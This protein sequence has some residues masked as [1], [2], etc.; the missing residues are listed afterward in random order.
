MSVAE[1]RTARTS[2]LTRRRLLT[3]GAT[4]ALATACGVPDSG[5]SN[6]GLKAA[7]Y[8]TPAYKDIFPSFQVL[9]DAIKQNSG[10]KVAYKMF[11]SEALLDAEQ[12]IPGILQGVADLGFQTSSYISTSYP[13]L[14]AYELPFLSDE[15][16]TQERMLAPD[17]PL[18]G[19]FN[20]EL[21]KKGLRML[22][23]ISTAYETIW[24]VDKPIRKPDDIKGMRIRTAG[25]VEGETVRALGGSPVSMSSAE[26]FQA[27]ERGTIDGMI[28]Y[29]GTVISRDLQQVLRHATMGPFGSYSV[30]A[31]VR[32]RWYD[33][34]DDALKDALLKSGK[35]FLERGTAS[36]LKVH[37][38]QY[39]PAIEKAGIEIFEPEGAEL[40][41]FE[42]ALRPVEQRWRARLGDDALADKALGMVRAA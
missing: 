12:L 41:A 31:Y 29:L 5:A 35:T 7:T 15:V 28:S 19:L 40:K 23:S 20:Q 42:D 26:L 2:T 17:G 32:K 38:E 25:F 4:A 6:T 10:G 1:P 16:A 34:L 13:I 36:L 24:T 33:E 37:E 39:M 11:H 30:D 18:Y 3:A 21:G 27:L 22:G 8:L 9:L 14:G